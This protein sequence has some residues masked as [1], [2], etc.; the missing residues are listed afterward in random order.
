MELTSQQPFWLLRDGLGEV[1]PPLSR[2]RR[3]DVAV[4]GAG[5]TGALVSDALT[6]AGLSV[7]AVDR[8]HPAHG[9][10][11]ASTA[12]LQ[13][14]LDV[15]LTELIDRLGSTRAVDS[16][17]AAL[18][19][20]RAIG[21]ICK[22]LKDDVG[23][24]NRPSLYYA[25]RKRDVNGLREECVE[26]GRAG[27]PCEVLESNAIRRIVGIRAPLALWSTAGAEVDPWRLTRALI[28]R[29]TRRDFA[30]Y[31]RT[32]VTRIVPDRTG[33][34]LRTTRG[35]IRAKT[36]IVAAG[37]EAERFLPE[38]L[39]KLH[40]TY[41]IVTEPVK[42]FDGWGTRCLVWES[43]RP[44]LYARTTFDNRI[45][46]GGEDDPFRNPA[47]RDARVPTKA[48]KLLRKARRL[49]P[50]IEM[51]LAYAW[52]GTF[53]ESKDS[54]PYIGPHPRGDSRVLYA[55]GYGAN[56]IPFS[57]VAAEVLTAKILGKPHR[58]QGTFAC[59]R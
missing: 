36:V 52:G 19:G 26:R 21:R 12:L 54:L 38:R 37:Y 8:R 27:L 51:E 49:F 29:S 23:F 31:G 44:Y 10:T 53:G 3:C 2:D 28:A 32:A 57:A 55:L 13:Y 40:S 34:E 20:V 22:S 25:S 14:E 58:Y 17:R 50:R 11:S 47:L 39:A 45:I 48:E 5:I 59:D 33:V 9:S 1:P 35:R 24:R 56:G 6:A 30:V 7:I 4:I 15:P 18:D 46:V 41:A 42:G 16:Y 43:A